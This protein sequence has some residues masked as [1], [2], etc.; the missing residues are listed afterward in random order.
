MYFDGN[1]DTGVPACV[2]CHQ[3]QGSGDQ[4]YP[5]IGGQHTQYVVQQLKNFATNERSNDT[6][7]Y[8]RVLAKRMSEEEIQAVAA[9]LVSLDSK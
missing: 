2:G 3:A 8:M 5:R 9:Y 6:G 7:R 1:E 4:V